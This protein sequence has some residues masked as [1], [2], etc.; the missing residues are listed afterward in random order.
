MT[1]GFLRAKSGSSATDLIAAF[2]VGL[3]AFL[4]YLATLAPTVM[5]N[6]AGRFQIAAPLLGTGHP[7]G[8]P[9]FILIGKLFTYL[10]VGD[11]AYRMNLMAGFFGGVAIALFYLVARELGSKSWPAAGFGLALAFSAL[12]W[13]EATFAE[14]Y[15][16]NASFLLGVVYLLLLWRRKREPAFLMVAALL[17]GVSLGN[18][19]SMALL[20]PLMLVLAVVGR[21]GEF[22][23]RRFF[24]AGAL[25]LLGFSV[26]LY[27]P[28]RGFA[29][30]WHNYGDPARTPEEVWRLVTGARFHEQMGRTPLETLASFEVYLRETVQ[31]SYWP[32][33]G[34][35]FGVLLLVGGVL[36]LRSI[37]LRDRVIGGF[38]ILAL[39]V[40]LL[41]A[42]NY[43]IGDIAV[44]YIPTYIYL[45]LGLAVG[46]SLLASRVPTGL[47]H[48]AVVLAPM[49]VAA[50]LF[51]TNYAESDQSDNY[52]H[53]EQAEEI[54]RE[55][56]PDAVLYGKLPVIPATYL[57]QIEGERPDVT[58]RW[59]DGDTQERYMR[60]DVESGRSVF[61]TRNPGYTYQYVKSAEGYAEPRYGE[62]LV[63]L[64]P[65]ED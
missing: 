49:V 38:L 55:L 24:G 61:I 28:I 15:T 60:S 41:Y 29:G 27:I 39:T 50:L 1:G 18:N 19:A 63:R 30:A 22:N 2:G 33:L 34:L 31:Q 20:A 65:R 25:S 4:A 6:D 62:K 37:L 53:R 9:T 40:Q 42:L 47:P 14:V 12:F 46:T 45:S 57:Q 44:Y 35:A 36:G 5:S 8:Y 26:Y 3:A 43:Q 56:P 51:A 21:V 54:F 10:P 23:A 11:V 48:A 59:M 64:V 13:S 7:T 32:L 52:F 16:M 17:Y 58:L